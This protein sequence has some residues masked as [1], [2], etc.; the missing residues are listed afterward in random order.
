MNKISDKIDIYRYFI[1][2]TNISRSVIFC[3]SFILLIIECRIIKNNMKNSP[4]NKIDENLT[5]EQFDSILNNSKRTDPLANKTLFSKPKS[6]I[7][8]KTKFDD[9]YDDSNLAIS[10]Y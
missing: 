8:H 3:F 2:I 6:E 1:I 9:S 5:K 4:L 10:N 7:N